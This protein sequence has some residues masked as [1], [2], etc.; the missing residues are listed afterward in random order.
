MLKQAFQARQSVPSAATA[1]E[2][3]GGA[4]G[5]GAASA[6]RG[7]AAAEAAEN[8]AVGRGIAPE[9]A[10]SKNVTRNFGGKSDLYGR[11]WTDDPVPT[12]SRNSLGLPAENTAEFQAHGTVVDKAGITRQPA[13]AIPEAG[14]NGKGGELVVPNPRTQIRVDAVTMPDTPLPE[15]LP[16][17][18]VLK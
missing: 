18:P 16:T 17:D 6:S 5:V 12:Q 7:A 3:V 4:R 8:G 9:A 11:S 14:V 13:R 2:A 15:A 1:G 10:T